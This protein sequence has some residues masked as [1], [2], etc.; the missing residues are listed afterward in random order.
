M[1]DVTHL[2]ATS[3]TTYK[4]LEVLEPIEFYGCL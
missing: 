4:H 3:E 1:M 2:L